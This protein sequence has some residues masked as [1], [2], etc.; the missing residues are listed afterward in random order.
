MRTRTRSETYRT[1]FPFYGPRSRT[2]KHSIY[3]DHKRERKKYIFRSKYEHRD[4]RMK[5][6]RWKIITHRASRSSPFRARQPRIKETIIENII[7]QSQANKKSS[8]GMHFLVSFLCLGIHQRKEDRRRIRCYAVRR[9][10][11]MDVLVVEESTSSSWASAVE[12]LPAREAGRSCLGGEP[13]SVGVRCFLVG[14][15][16]T[17]QSA[18]RAIRPV[19]ELSAVPEVRIVIGV[20]SLVAAESTAELLLVLRALVH[21]A[22]CALRTAEATGTL[23]SHAEATETGLHTGRGLA[24][25]GARVRLVAELTER[26][27]G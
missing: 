18:A 14:V 8:F 25:P 6:R 26:G 12:I 24:V 7:T 4:E 2:N 23:G 22:T 11:E 16:E 21:E 20:L 27:G 15:C 10:R 19:L 17:P 3:A 9:V 5:K 1:H 13:G